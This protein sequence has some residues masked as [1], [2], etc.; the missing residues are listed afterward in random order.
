MSRP[1]ACSLPAAHRSSFQLT[2]RITCVRRSPP[3]RVAAA[4]PAAD[5]HEGLKARDADLADPWRIGAVS[6]SEGR[7]CSFEPGS[8]I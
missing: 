4:A 7:H 6:S 8:Q 5:P 1:S 3:T 2:S